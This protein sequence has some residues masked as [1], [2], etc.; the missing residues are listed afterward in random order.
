MLY[1][2]KINDDLI[3][4]G[5]SDRSKSIF[6]GVYPIPDG[7]SYN[8]Y[9]LKD[10]KC[11]LFDTADSSLAGQFI[12]NLKSG[13]GESALDYIV[14]LH[15]E[16]DHSGTLG[17]L[18]GLYPNATIVCSAKAKSMIAQLLGYEPK[19]VNVIK[20]GDKLSLGK[21]NLKFVGAPMVHWPEVMVCFDT[22]DGI[23]FS[24]DAFGTFGALDG[25]LFADEVDFESECIDEARRYY[26]NIVG[27]YGTPVKVLLNKAAALEIK[28]VCPLHGFVWRDNIS[29]IVNKYLHWAEYKP[30]EEGVCICYASIYG[31]TEA[32]A[33]ALSAR[34]NERGIKTD[35]VDLTHEHYSFGIANCF[36][37]SR[38][39]MASVTYNATIF[40][41][42]RTFL[43]EYAD[44]GIKG[45]KVGLIENGTWAATAAKEMREIIEKCPNTT[46]IDKVISI[47][48]S[49][50]AEVLA[51][52]DGFIDDL[53]A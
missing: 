12:D 30:E 32:V 39:V 16:P 15:M 2:R 8:S 9:L 11:A 38:A 34:L 24:A 27:K 40:T 48:S 43:H 46:V 28:T 7:M 26:T 41:P 19:N 45:R 42:M 5:V 49:A 18:L 14:V 50:N 13:L 10:E 3:Y 51:Q 33:Y 6:E 17:L 53:M 47:K 4:I 52:I 29:Y 1:N 35:M 37:Y 21:H 25:K 36:K 20:E 44:H 23:L 31:N 22:T